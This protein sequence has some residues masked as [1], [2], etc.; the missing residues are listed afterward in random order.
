[1][2]M[3]DDSSFKVEKLTA[4]NYHIW[5]FNIKMYLIGKDLWG[6][7]TGAETLGEN[8]TEKERKNFKKRENQAL[9]MICLAISTSLQIYVRS[10]QTPT[11]AWDN[12]ERH[13]QQKTL[14]KKIFYRRKLYASRMASSQ[15][16][17]EHINNIK[18]LAEHLEAIDDKVA[19]KDLVIILISSLPEEYNY[20]ITALETIA[21]D[22]LTWDYVRDRLIHESEKLS[23]HSEPTNDALLSRESKKS[24]KCHYCKK[25][26]HYARD[27]RK[28]KA[29]MKR[30]EQS[31]VGNFV[32]NDLK[33]RSK[34][35]L[36]LKS[37][38]PVKDDAE[39]LIDSGA[40]QHMTPDKK[41]ID[42]FSNFN[43]P[44]NVKLADDRIL[45]SY[46]KGDVSLTVFNGK[47]KVNLTLKDVLYVPKLQNNLFSLP[48]ATAKGASFEFKGRTCRVYMEG[49][50]YVIGHKHGKLYKLNTI[51]DETCC[52][53]KVNDKESLALWHLRYG[54]LNFDSLKTL[55]D[56]SMVNGMSVD[57]NQ[58]FDRNCEG[59]IMGKHHRQ[60]F[61]KKAESSTTHMLELIHSDVCGPMNINSVGGSKYFITFTD[62]FTRFVTVYMMKRKSEALEKFK[63]Y[64][65]LV[66]KQT[67]HKVKRLRCDNGGEYTSK[68]F[69]DYCKSN[70]IQR[71]L[72][73]PYSPQQN[74]IA[75]RL[76]RTLMEMARSIMYHSG[77]PM[78]FWAE[79][80]SS[81][82]YIRNRCP[83]AALKDVTPFERWYNKK[84]DV[85]NLKVFGC[86]AFVHVPDSKRKG[87]LSKKSLQCVFIGY[88]SNGNGFKL[89][90][91]TT[92][93]MFS[94]RDVV[95][96]EDKFWSDTNECDDEGYK[97]YTDSVTFDITNEEDETNQTTNNQENH[98]LDE[99][100]E[101]P[102]R[103]RR[104]PDRL[105][106]LTGEWWNFTNAASTN[107]VDEPITIDEALNGPNAKEWSIATKSEIDSLKQNKTWDL[108][109]PPNDKNIVGCKWV[110]K[111]KRDENGD[112]QRFKARL[113]AQ[114]YSQKPGI[115]YDEVFA[116]VARYNSIRSI[117]AIVNEFDLELHQMDVKTAF[118]HG[119]LDEEIY[120]A[121][122]EG[123][124]DENN[125]EKVCKLRKSL[126]G[127]KQ[128]ARC[129]NQALHKF[130]IESDYIQSNADPCIYIKRVKLNDKECLVIVAVYVDDLI[131]ASNDTVILL[132]EKRKLSQRFATVDQGEIKFC[133]GMS[134]K[135]DRKLG[136]LKIDQIAYLKRILEKFG[137][138]DCKP[139]STPME[140]NKHFQKSTET[141][142]IKLKEYQSAI[143]SLLYAAIGTRPDLAFS[144]GVLSQFM[145]NPGTEHWVGVKRIFRYL[146]GTLN[147]GLKFVSSKTRTI[148]LQ[149]YADADW[150]GDKI[151]RKSTSGF[152][153]QIG[154]STVTWSSR[155]QSIVALSSAEAEYVSLSDASQEAVW[156]Q[157]LLDELGFKQHHKI[158]LHEDN[159]AAIAL[160]K[161]GKYSSRTKH[162]DVKYHYVRQ[163]IE[164]GKLKVD[165]CPTED[166]IAD[167]MTKSL[168]RVKF[169]K[170][171]AMLRVE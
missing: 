140:A 114:G 107:D 23:K 115:D 147:L 122:P 46:G 58:D 57:S 54:H 71:E 169:E 97:F 134:I 80:L 19:E 171:R 160:A 110:F 92:R 26:G 102:R 168:S 86:K 125:P 138:A 63:E 88:P 38:N 74:G 13:F 65:N 91:P 128:A 94:S 146:K 68:A 109:D 136:I 37:S 7:V 36:A 41:I 103:I 166:M 132:E 90:N 156:L 127:L 22:Q 49:K 43:K 170:L 55:N 31:H 124:V 167:I 159:Q 145:S 35:E 61:P 149:G 129:W 6:I 137:M 9:A 117:L 130:L 89:Y 1:M 10:A 99:E 4:D 119:E 50:D 69:V 17:T 164:D 96:A 83:T 73:V 158:T 126:Y 24:F 135:R 82:V 51:P 139:I 121:Q 28:K 104:P 143:G 66:E 72:T 120:M 85:S 108:V 162:I 106:A 44:L 152:V 157:R 39:W 67:G 75:E 20:L 16:M 78:S 111:H 56:K 148:N 150:A 163:A 79:A 53:G 154:D 151:S 93:Q 87:K 21:D 95:F 60:P 33:G 133:L 113:V 98:V 32:T 2:D 70:G 12:L 14:S 27:C 131:I 84:P 77:V 5:K 29:D 100:T 47:E 3:A 116:P 76:N 34:S 59:C 15:D 161:N 11:E 141:Q 52:I 123:F 30:N 64:V 40:S 105:N 144:V 142:P 45:L 8:A 62:D 18:T 118:L 153:F 155:R 81:A 101:R 165:Y 42:N 25:P 48:S 112:I